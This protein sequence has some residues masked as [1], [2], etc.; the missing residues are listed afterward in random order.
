MAPRSRALAR[1]FY[2]ADLAHVQHAGFG[3]FAGTAAP[4]LLATLRWAG[5]RRGTVL[6]LGCGAG[7]WLAALG[8]AD[9]DAI[10]IEM[11]PALA[12]F[13]RRAAPRARVTVGS[14]YAI[15]LP[16]CDAVTALGEVLGY[17]PD[18][19]SRIPSFGAFFRRVAKALRPGGVFAFDLIVRNERR[20]LRTR[21]Y[22]IGDDWAVLAEA[23]EDPKRARL[24]RDITIFRRRGATWRRTHEVHHVRVPSREEITSALGAAG[25][26]RVRASRRYGGF[27]L[28]P[29][30]LAF[31]ARRR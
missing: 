27:A 9:Y 24:V 28:M 30:R 25:F 29:H 2:G 18:D 1:G 17:L 15:P 22:R 5:I 19:G 6:D 10:G 21:N 23:I 26:D 13:A 20:P 16:R 3:D 12:R 8:A 7:P 31:V 11:S 4:G 14:I